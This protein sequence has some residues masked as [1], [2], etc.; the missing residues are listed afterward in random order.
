MM[1]MP[2]VRVCITSILES[3]EL[4][5]K[6]ESYLRKYPFQEHLVL[7]IQKRLSFKVDVQCKEHIIT[8]VCL[9][10]GG[11]LLWLNRTP[12]FTNL[13]ALVAQNAPSR[14]QETQSIKP[15]FEV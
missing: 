15:D 11:T 1:G 12:D 13:R 3:H 5:K 6:E 7:M 9:P 4:A 14:I 2:F 8:C 10:G